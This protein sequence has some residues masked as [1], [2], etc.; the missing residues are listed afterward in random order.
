MRRDLAQAIS[1]YERD[2]TLS[3]AVIT[4]AGG[5]WRSRR[6]LI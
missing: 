4:G 5:P 1:I 2:E 6:E 3:A